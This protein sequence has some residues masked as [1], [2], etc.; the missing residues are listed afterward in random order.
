MDM[1]TLHMSPDGD[2]CTASNIIKKDIEPESDKETG[3]EWD[4]GGD[5]R[6]INGERDGLRDRE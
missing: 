6:R 2:I 4:V 1:T 5:K 3:R